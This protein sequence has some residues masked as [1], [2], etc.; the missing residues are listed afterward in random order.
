ME[1]FA[2]DVFW[3]LLSL[4]V[5]VLKVAEGFVSRNGYG[6]AYDS[7]ATFGK[8]RRIRTVL[9]VPKAWFWHFYLLASVWGLALFV[10]WFEIGNLSIYELGTVSVWLQHCPYIIIPIFIGCII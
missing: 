8:T 9:D 4:A 3:L 7:L 2:L 6:R 5:I 1:L 10:R